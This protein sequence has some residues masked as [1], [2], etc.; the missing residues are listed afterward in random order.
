MAN[1]ERVCEPS[2]KVMHE[3]GGK[4]IFFNR[5]AKIGN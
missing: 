4:I 2:G 5:F 3:V 1:L